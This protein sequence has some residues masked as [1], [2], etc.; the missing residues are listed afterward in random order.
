MSFM[1]SGGGRSLFDGGDSEVTRT[2]LLS[3]G[4]E[5]EVSFKGDLLSEDVEGESLARTNLVAEG[6]E[7]PPEDEPVVQA[8]T[9]RLAEEE[10]P[11]DEGEGPQ[12]FTSRI[13][14]EEGP[15]DEGEGELSSIDGE[16]YGR[17]DTLSITDSTRDD[18]EFEASNFG[19]LD[20]DGGDL[21]MDGAGDGE[22]DAGMFDPPFSDF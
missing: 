16:T 18:F 7:E 20:P 9:S 8:F 13:A 12:A 11:E 14:E 2:D 3:E 17:L 1:D 6:E 19:E 10:G 15:E 5:E 4:F 21:D 22:I